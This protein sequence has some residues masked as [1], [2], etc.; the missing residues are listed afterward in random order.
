MAKLRC[1]NCG[2]VF[3]KKTLTSCVGAGV[4][5]VGFG[6]GAAVLVWPFVLRVYATCPVCK[7]KGWIKVLPPWGKHQSMQSQ[8]RLSH[9]FFCSGPISSGE[10]G[11][12]RE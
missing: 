3:G 6:A 1:L 10:V 2:N 12:T 5:G 4:S 8:P 7:Q 9:W 11:R